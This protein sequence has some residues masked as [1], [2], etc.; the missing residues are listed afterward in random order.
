MKNPLK[1]QKKAKA[2]KWPKNGQKMATKNYNKAL[3]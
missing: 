2:K 3:Y 1:T